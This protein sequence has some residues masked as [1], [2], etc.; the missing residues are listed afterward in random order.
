MTKPHWHRCQA[1]DGLGYLP[2]GRF[3]GW[4]EHDELCVCNAGK[5]ECIEDCREKDCDGFVDENGEMVER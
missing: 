5:I 1:C 2:A 4:P 3:M